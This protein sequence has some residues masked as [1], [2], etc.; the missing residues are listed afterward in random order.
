MQ[1][2]I[3]TILSFI[4]IQQLQPLPKYWL[5]QV[6]VEDS[7]FPGNVAHY[8][9]ETVPPPL[10]CIKNIGTNS[11][12]YIARP[13][14]D[15]S[16]TEITAYLTFNSTNNTSPTQPTSTETKPATTTIDEMMSQYISSLL[17]SFPSIVATTG[18]TAEKLDFPQT[19]KEATTACLACGM[20]KQG[21]N[22]KKWL[23]DITVTQAAPQQQQQEDGQ[24]GGTIEE[25]EGEGVDVTG[26]VCY[27]CYTLFRGLRGVVE[28]P[29]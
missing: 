9:N 13:L 23:D 6:K 18:H 1:R 10:P 3:I 2:R 20:P 5:L 11:D 16:D 28:W 15:L 12:I 24:G 26:E 19:D 8:S 22:V 25:G 4:A 29:I 21:D 27:G 17:T 7:L 14:K